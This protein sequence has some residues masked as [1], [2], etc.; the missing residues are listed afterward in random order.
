MDKAGADEF[1]QLAAEF[2]IAHLSK[3]VIQKPE[4]IKGPVKAHH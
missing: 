3:I 1:I 2:T 4:V